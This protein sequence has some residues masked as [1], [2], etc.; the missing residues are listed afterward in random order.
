MAQVLAVDGDGHLF[1]NS[2]RILECLEEPH[3]EYCTKRSTTA[4]CAR[5]DASMAC[6][7]PNHS[8]TR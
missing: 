2:A 7:N 5:P 3:R 1:E 6:P 8:P 4:C